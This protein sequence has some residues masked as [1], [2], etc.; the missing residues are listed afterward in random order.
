MIHNS[1]VI[2]S[3]AGF[4]ADSLR[5][6]LHDADFRVL[7][8]GNDI[9]LSSK[10]KTFYPRFIFIEQC[11]INNTTDEYV[12]KIMKS[13]INLH[14]VI[15]TVSDILPL[16]AARF[17]HAGAESFFSLR[18]TGENIEKIISRIANGKTYC[19]DDVEAVLDSDWGEPIFGVPLSKREIQIIK[20]YRYSDK[21]IAEKLSITVSTVKYH[22]TNIYRKVGG[23]RKNE[24]ITIA[25]RKGIIRLEDIL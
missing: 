15:W 10:I 12:E 17:I 2:A 8:A 23:I 7:V 4:L 5:E 19:P 24:V 13:N 18:D 1:V 11:F 25:V 21:V 6:K 9:E 16:A 20:L 22:K 14:I 3:T